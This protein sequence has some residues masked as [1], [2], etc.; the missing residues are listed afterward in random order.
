MLTIPFFS[1]TAFLG[2][3]EGVHFLGDLEADKKGGLQNTPV[4][5]DYA[6]LI[7]LL[8]IF[9]F[10]ATIGFTYLVYQH[11]HWWY[12]PLLFFTVLS[13]LALGYARGNIYN[14]EKLI[15]RFTWATKTAISFGNYVFVYQLLIIYL[16]SRQ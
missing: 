16:L 1:L 10:G 13:I 5:L 4:V 6:N 11:S 2:V 15:T 9:A 14:T 3:A 8:I 12:Y 7:K